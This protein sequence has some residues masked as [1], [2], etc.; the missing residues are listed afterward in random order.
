VRLTDR[1]AIARHLRRDASLHLYELGDLDPFFWPSTRWWGLGEPPE[2]IAMTYDHPQMPTLLALCRPR[3]AD[4]MNALLAAIADELPER[5]HAH[6]GPGVG[7]EGWGFDD[8]GR[9]DKMVLTDPRRCDL[10]GDDVQPLGRHDRAEVEAF[11]A[12][13]YPGNWFD[14]RMLETEAYRGI[15]DENRLV[16]VAGVHVLSRE[17]RVAALGNIATDP[18]R[19]G[20][21]FG[22]RVTAAVCRRL[23]PDTDAIGLNVEADN[24]VAIRCYRGLGF[25]RAASY[26]EAILTRS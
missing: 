8:R 18:S 10:P 4:A 19:R 25:D 17:Q 12:R 1:A 6:L 22:T 21:G 14:P 11:Y 5:I 24:H 26:R 15:R 23:A 2:V 3:E 13:C 9:Y 20:R 16:S 7:L